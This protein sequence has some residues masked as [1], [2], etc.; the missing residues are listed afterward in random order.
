MLQSPIKNLS[1]Q[2][3]NMRFIKIPA[4][5]REGEGR[6]A[7]ARERDLHFTGD[8]PSVDNKAVMRRARE[9]ER[10]RERETYTSRATALPSTINHLCALP[11]ADT[12][13]SARNPKFCLHAT[14]SHPLP[15]FP[16]M[17]F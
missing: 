2:M 13:A 17:L 7:R 12:C 5:E 9:R 8:S 10:E 6:R 15:R 3:R 14:Q 4:T 1:L 11:P 16:L